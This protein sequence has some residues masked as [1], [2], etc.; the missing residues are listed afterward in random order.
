ME[1]KQFHLGDVISITTGCLMSPRHIEGVYDILNFMT[2]D[3]LFTHQLGR[4]AEECKPHL[5]RQHP[6]LATI[7]IEHV[8]ADNHSEI[9]AGLCAEYGETLLVTELPEHSHEFIDP[10]SELV[11]KVH[12]DNIVTVTL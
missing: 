7:D 11:E 3:N 4:A 1:S 10:M 8:T 12:P 6:Q 9:L 2:R 5:L